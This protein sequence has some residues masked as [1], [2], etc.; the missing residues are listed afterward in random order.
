MLNGIEY[1]AENGLFRRA[2]L[3][4]GAYRIVVRKNGYREEAYD[5]SVAAGDSRPLNINLKLA[6]GVVNV[7]PTVAGASI[8]IVNAETNREVGRYDGRADNVALAPGRY[9]VAVSKQGYRTAVREVTVEDART[10]YLEPPL[11]ALPAQ[12][13]ER[14]RTGRASFRPDAAT[15]VQVAAEGKYILIYLSGRSGDME[16]T[17]GPVDVTLGGDYIRAGGAATVT[18]MLTGFPCQVDFV[19]LENVA[20]YSFV[21]PPGTSNLWG[22][23]V[24]RVRP[25]DSKRAI[26]FLINW[27]R[28]PGVP[29]NTPP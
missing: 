20:E 2:E 24:V 23:V 3:R 4:P 21:E 1:R 22:R 9:Q 11:E 16:S 7:A 17:V 5:L 19:K 25:K 10:L 12:A 8:S 6:A 13:V 27:K 14:R 18:G 15:Q 28:L 26:H 29:L